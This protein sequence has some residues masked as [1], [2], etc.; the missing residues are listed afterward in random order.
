MVPDNTEHPCVKRKEAVENDVTSESNEEQ[1][2]SP[3]ATPLATPLSTDCAGQL[4]E[5]LQIED[6]ES[7]ESESTTPKEYCLP[8]AD[9]LQS[10]THG[11]DFTLQT[12]G[13]CK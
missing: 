2:I 5:Q 9:Q 13:T 7:L 1:E 3:L 4:V 11:E 8:T 6:G 12:A 10:R